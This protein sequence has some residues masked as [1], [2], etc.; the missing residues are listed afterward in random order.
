[1]SYMYLPHLLPKHLYPLLSS[2]KISSHIFN[3][4]FI[5]KLSSN[6]N[7]ARK[8]QSIQALNLFYFPIYISLYLLFKFNF[9]KVNKLKGI[10]IE[11][12]S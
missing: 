9:I 12:I 6:I 1:M 8:K 2:E 3:T 10:K 11:I 7:G 4:L 5:F